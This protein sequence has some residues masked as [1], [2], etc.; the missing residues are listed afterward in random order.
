MVVE[1]HTESSEPKVQ[2]RL[3]SD[4]GT[5]YLPLGC[6]HDVTVDLV[7]HGDRSVVVIFHDGARGECAPRLRAVEQIEGWLEEQHG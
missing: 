2:R 5:I 3:A 6:D 4:I 1:Q 7:Y